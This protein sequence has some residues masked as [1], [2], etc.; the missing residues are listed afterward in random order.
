MWFYPLLVFYLGMVSA[1]CFYAERYG[2]EPER[3]GALIVGSATVLTMGFSLGMGNHF[4]STESAVLIIDIITGA[5]FF[6]LA[7]TSNRY[8]P[9]WAT[10]FQ[11]IAIMTHLAVLIDR[12]IVPQA[13]AAGQGFWAYPVLVALLLGSERCRRA[14]ARQTSSV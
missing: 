2:S 6:W 9:L 1:T 12:S 13:Y 7:L 11:S 8:W 14:E 4:R 10:A 5:A 3:T